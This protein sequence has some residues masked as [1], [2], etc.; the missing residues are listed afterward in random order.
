MIPPLLTQKSLV[1]LPMTASAYENS[2]RTTVHT[3]LPVHALSCSIRSCAFSTIRVP[4]MTR[5]I[6]YL[7]SSALTSLRCCNETGHPPAALLLTSIQTSEMAP[8]SRVT[9]A[10]SASQSI[11]PLYC[12]CEL[13]SNTAGCGSS[14]T[15]KPLSIS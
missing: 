5:G 15:V 14:F 3:L 10:W 7:V 11:L 2:S 1:K 8:G 13:R 12:S 9:S 6:E 4:S